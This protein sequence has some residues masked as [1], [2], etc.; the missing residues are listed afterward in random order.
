MSQYHPRERMGSKGYAGE[1]SQLPW[2]HPLTRVVLTSS[3]S[4]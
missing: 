3:L 4:D 2:A 1:T